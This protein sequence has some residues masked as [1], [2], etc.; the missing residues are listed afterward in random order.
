MKKHVFFV[1]LFGSIV[2]SFF[3]AQEHT[4]RYTIHLFPEHEQKLLEYL[5]DNDE[6]DVANDFL[7]VSFCSD[8]QKLETCLYYLRTKIHVAFN[9]LMNMNTTR[10]AEGS[11]FIPQTVVLCTDGTISIAE[12]PGTGCRLVHDPE[13]PDSIKSGKNAGYVQYPGINKTAELMELYTTINLYNVFADVYMDMFP[14]C[15]VIKESY[16]VYVNLL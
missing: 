6:A 10:T 16:S 8:K 14:E 7:T 3:S 13:H 1:F 5:S 11:C 2:I 4:Q 15:H 12:D 9:N